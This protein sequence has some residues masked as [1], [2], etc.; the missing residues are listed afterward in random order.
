MYN[1]LINNDNNFLQR[2]RILSLL[3]RSFANSGGHAHTCSPL[4]L[5][6]AFCGFP[7]LPSRQIHRRKRTPES[8]NDKT[9]QALT[10]TINI[11]YR[12]KSA[13]RVLQTGGVNF[14]NT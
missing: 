4:L 11:Y 7:Y 14:K 6:F 3:A 10:Q 2:R 9:K 5:C 1:I 13:N 8:L 12:L